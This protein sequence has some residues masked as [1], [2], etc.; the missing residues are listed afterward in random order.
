MR[1]MLM[2]R[3]AVTVLLCFLLLLS[4]CTQSEIEPG[5][6]STPETPSAPA[7]PSGL[8]LS[9]I[10]AD[11]EAGTSVAALSWQ[12]VRGAS[13]V[14]LERQDPLFSD[15][16][17]KLA[18][19]SANITQYRDEGVI[20]GRPYRY[21][22]RAMNAAGT[23]PYSQEVNVTPLLPDTT[24][25]FDGADLSKW[26]PEEP[27]GELWPVEDGALEVLPLGNVGD[28]D[29]R[30]QEVYR[31]F[32]LHVEFNVPASPE[33][34][35]EQERGNSG[36]YLQGRYE[37][38]VL[39]SYG[40]TLEGE[41][42]VGAVYGVSDASTNASL[43]AGEWQ[44][45]DILFTAPRYKDDASGDKTK[46][47]DARVSVRLNGTLIQNDVQIP[48]STR[49]GNPEGSEVG[50]VVLQAHRDRVRYRNLWLQPLD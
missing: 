44:R 28:N 43:P 18:T 5:L 26:E 20:L 17:E 46:I 22:L 34:T 25:L 1:L 31:D 47:E 36:I 2:K 15:S 38:Q 9:E 13:E 11:F 10:T 23:S 37:I 14:E 33:D 40:R 19:L 16:F 6:P 48:N 27:G 39:D 35:D 21:R 49:L 30:T 29:L 45:Y 8:M 12:E 41:N 32:W 42:D 24:V 50:P 7:I 4:S 3:G